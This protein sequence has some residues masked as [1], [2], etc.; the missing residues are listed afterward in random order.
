MTRPNV[1]LSRYY[2]GE[3][4]RLEY[5]AHS[6]MELSQAIQT[7]NERPELPLLNEGPSWHG[8]LGTEGVI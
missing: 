5:I 2:R 1:T 4:H 8:S 6:D 3:Y 7:W